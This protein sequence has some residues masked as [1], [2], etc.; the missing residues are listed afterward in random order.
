M[1]VSTARLLV[2]AD[3][4]VVVDTVEV[5]LGQLLLDKA[6]LVELVL[7]LAAAVVE[8]RVQLETQEVVELAALVVLVVMVY[9]HLFQ[10]LLHTMR[11]VVAADLVV[12][13]LQELED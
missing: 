10:E 1:E 2:L 8:V 4:V 5:Q 13:E 7:V 3:Q 9:S 6:L 12:A 11:V